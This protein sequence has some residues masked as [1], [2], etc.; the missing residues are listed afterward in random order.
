MG[1]GTPGLRTVTV[2][3]AGGSGLSWRAALPA[4]VLGSSAFL[5]L[6]LF[7][8]FF[9]GGA[10][11]HALDAA[12]GPVLALLAVLVVGGV[13][14]WLIRRGRRAGSQAFSEA[15]CPACLAL[16]LLSERYPVV[17]ELT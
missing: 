13:G 15:C 4:L 5:Q 6:H 8:G 12:R 17:A 10:A 16:G 11:R 2:A 9:L 1:R 14:F 3:A 7:L